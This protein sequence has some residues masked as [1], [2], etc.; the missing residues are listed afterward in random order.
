MFSPPAALGRGFEEEEPEEIDDTPDW[1]KGDDGE[2][3][4]EYS[5]ENTANLEQ[6]ESEA[7]T[8]YLTAE[9][10]EGLTPAWKQHLGGDAAEGGADGAADADDDE[11][12]GSDEG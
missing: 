5:W 12:E 6:Y 1:L 11:E 7:Y 2:N 10:P 8:R 9:R 4:D 3:D